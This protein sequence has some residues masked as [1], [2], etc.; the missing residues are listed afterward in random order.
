[1][2]WIRL[3]REKLRNED[4]DEIENKIKWEKRW[5]GMVG[6]DK[7]YGGVGKKGNF[8]KIKMRK[9][10]KNKKIEKN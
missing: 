8:G 5:I 2:W 3:E 7:R 10:M 9:I 6:I 4:G 1:M